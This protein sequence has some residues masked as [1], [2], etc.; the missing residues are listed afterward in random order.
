MFP[1]LKIIQLTQGHRKLF[2]M[3]HRKICI[4]L[5]YLV[6]GDFRP[7]ITLNLLTVFIVIISLVY[8]VLL[9][10]FKA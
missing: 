7:V 4:A 3:Q 2:A 10:C 5:L 8:T 6:R 9:T 1:T